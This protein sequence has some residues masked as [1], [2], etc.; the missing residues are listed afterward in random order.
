MRYRTS[1]NKIMPESDPITTST[2]P[3]KL[4]WWQYAEKEHG[5]FGD[6][7][8]RLLIAKIFNKKTVWAPSS[9]CDIVGAGSIIDH[10]LETKGNN[11]PCLWGAGFIK[12]SDSRIGEETF[13]IAALRGKLSLSR[14]DVTYPVALGDPGILASYLLD[15]APVIKKFKL[16]L[17]PH[18]IDYETDIV[19]KLRNLSTDLI[20]I[21]PT[22]EC[23]SVIQTISEC[24]MIL[25]SSLHGLIVADSLSIPNHRLIISDN[26]VDGEY[27]FLDYYSVYDNERYNPML[28]ESIMDLS[29]ADICE[30]VLDNYKEPLGIE[31]IKKRLIESF[32]LK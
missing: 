14:A 17:I 18:Y 5:N 31:K 8:T 12:E 24:E 3:I 10:V 25:S 15:S 21:D 23:Q 32:P 9:Q 6:E 4:Y 29:L 27:K 28:P 20:V 11:R 13:G 26:L 19:K 1:Y 22:Q 30:L 2:Q 7:I 16:G